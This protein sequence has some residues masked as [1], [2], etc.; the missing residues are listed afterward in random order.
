MK[1]IIALLMFSL[2]STVWALS[3]GDSVTYILKVR[4]TSARLRVTEKVVDILPNLGDFLVK[5]SFGTQDWRYPGAYISKKEMITRGWCQP[6]L[7]EVLG[8]S[9]DT[10]KYDYYYNPAYF[11][12]LSGEYPSYST[13]FWIGDGPYTNII[14]MRTSGYDGPY[15]GDRIYLL[16][17]YINN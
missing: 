7:I 9:Y 11:S 8:K 16:E 1:V 2:L 10:C 4:D 12:A 14:K 15:H 6:E 13:V 3:V 5:S 17:S